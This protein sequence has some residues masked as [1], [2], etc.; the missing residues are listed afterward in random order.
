MVQ[1]HRAAQRCNKSR[2][3]TPDQTRPDQSSPVSNYL[4][5]WI[6][7]AGAGQSRAGQDRARAKHG[8]LAGLDWLA[9]QEMLTSC[10]KKKTE[11]KPRWVAI[12][13]NRLTI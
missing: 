13:G 1:A 5:I 4:E 12:K 7:L 10:A 11:N 2:S 6:E 3:I 8:W 9:G